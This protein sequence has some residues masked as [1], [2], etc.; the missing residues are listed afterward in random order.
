MRCE[1]TSNIV[2]AKESLSAASAAFLYYST[3]SGEGEL[4]KNGLGVTNRC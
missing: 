1:S 3:R 4:F 2:K